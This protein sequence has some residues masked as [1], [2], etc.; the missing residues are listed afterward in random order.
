M[1]EEGSRVLLFGAMFGRSLDGHI[2]VG[3]GPKGFGVWF[4]S[5][6]MVTCK[7]GSLG[8]W[9]EGVICINLFYFEEGC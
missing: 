2:G 1:S 8:N 4:R 5:Y 9:K 6:E 7:K 3:Q